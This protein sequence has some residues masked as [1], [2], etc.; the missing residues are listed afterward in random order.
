M[1]VLCISVRGVL[2]VSRLMQSVYY[3]CK[4]KHWNNWRTQCVSLS[5]VQAKLKLLGSSQILWICFVTLNNLTLISFRLWEKP[6]PFQ[7]LCEVCVSPHSPLLPLP[8]VTDLSASC[9]LD[10]IFFTAFLLR[11]NTAPL[12]F[13]PKHKQHKTFQVYNVLRKLRRDGGEF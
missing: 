3:F 6:A 13:L 12:L 11:L 1:E 7:S 8:M 5:S 9:P 10:L 4:S 2:W